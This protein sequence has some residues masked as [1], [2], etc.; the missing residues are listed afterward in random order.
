[1]WSALMGWSGLSRCSRKTKRYFHWQISAAART[2][3]D[4]WRA[5]ARFS[6]WRRGFALSLRRWRLSAQVLAAV[7]GAWQ[8][9][10]GV[11]VEARWR[12]LALAA[13]PAARH[14]ES[15]TCA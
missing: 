12:A 15:D 9:W 1:M 8:Q 14:G 5:Q 3:V 13:P 6:A 7:L 11:V 4:I 10:E 2:S